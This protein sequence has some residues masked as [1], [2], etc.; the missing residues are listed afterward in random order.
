MRD[1]YLKSGV[2]RAEVKPHTADVK[3]CW[4]SG[5]QFFIVLL[6]SVARVIGILG[7]HKAF[8]MKISCDSWRN[9]ERSLHAPISYV[10]MSLLLSP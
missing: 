2:T 4:L 8:S 5:E 9:K 10:T 1:D 3:W 6:L 7:V